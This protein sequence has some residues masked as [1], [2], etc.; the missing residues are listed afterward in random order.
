MET[1]QKLSNVGNNFCFK[2]TE[3]IGIAPKRSRSIKSHKSGC[4]ESN[5]TPIKTVSCLWQLSVAAGEKE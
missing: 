5:Q 2:F 4:T 1:K 3:G